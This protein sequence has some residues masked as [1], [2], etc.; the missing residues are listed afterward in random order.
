M[1]T[2]SGSNILTEPFRRSENL[3][4]CLQAC[5]A[6]FEAQLA[7]P[8]SD[9]PTVPFTCTCPL[10]FALVTTSRLALLDASP[11]WQPALAHS[12]FDFGD[13]ARRIA[14]QY[15]R[16]EQWTR[17]TDTR[18]RL[19]DD[20]GS[21]F[22]KYCFK[23]RW[24]RQWYQSKISPDQ[25]HATPAANAAAAEE[26]GEQGDMLQFADLD[27]GNSMWEELFSSEDPT[28]LAPQNPGPPM[29]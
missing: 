12:K 4:K 3:W 21:I 10:S 5:Q 18:H 22:T 8:I 15:E 16:A 20:G 9:V 2:P 24:V 29:T 1:E 11:D 7:V 27:W 6:F 25:Q 28:L 19:V 13:V 26:V 14:V 23:L 17:E